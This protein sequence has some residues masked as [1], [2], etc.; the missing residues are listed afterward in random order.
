MG[1]RLIKWDHL[2]RHV[3]NHT[4][5]RVIICEHVP[6][7]GLRWA[8]QVMT[9]PPVASGTRGVQEVRPERVAVEPEGGR[10]DVV[11]PRIVDDEAVLRGVARV[12]HLLRV[13]ARVVEKGRRVDCG[14]A[15][16]HCSMWYSRLVAYPHRMKVLRSSVFSEL[17]RMCI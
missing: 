11:L 17:V 2:H 5:D 13:V 4:Y 1:G 8:L 7:D 9:L 15:V 16:L 6:M 3:L 14:S 10:A 12:V